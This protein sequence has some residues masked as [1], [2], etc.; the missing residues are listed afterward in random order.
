MLKLLRIDHLKKQRLKVSRQV[1]HHTQIKMSAITYVITIQSAF[2][3][4]TVHY[5]TQTVP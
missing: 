3:N 5:C 4:H 1:I 2:M